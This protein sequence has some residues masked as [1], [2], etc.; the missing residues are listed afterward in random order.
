M[1]KDL[2]G[3]SKLYVKLKHYYLFGKNLRTNCDKWDGLNYWEKI[4]CGKLNN[5]SDLD[6]D[7]KIK[8][9]KLE[10]LL[11]FLNITNPTENNLEWKLIQDKLPDKNTPKYNELIEKLNLKKDKKLKNKYFK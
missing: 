5:F 4:V 7:F 10:I 2:K 8:Y 6:L 11:D 1:E 3:V 9:F